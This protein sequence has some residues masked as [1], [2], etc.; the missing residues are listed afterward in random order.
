MAR[1]RLPA[2]PSSA[3]PSAARSRWRDALSDERMAHLVKTAFRGTSRAL[4]RRLARHHV[5]YG[6]WTLLRVLWQADGLT[7]RE[8]AEQAG[9]AESSAF[10]A[11]GRMEQQGYVRRSK[12]PG[13]NK[14]V[15]VFLTPHGAALRASSIAAAEEVNRLALRG[16]TAEDMAATRRTL[17]AMI[18]NLDAE[19]PALEEDA[20]AAG[21]RRSARAA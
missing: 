12:L 9:V 3:S 16:V 1:T 5:Q 17:I 20:T 13:N 11:L 4:Q 8:L 6:Q 18:E 2:A 15:R 19:Q 21:A 7:Q 10:V 14:L